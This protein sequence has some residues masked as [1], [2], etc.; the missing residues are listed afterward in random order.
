M[1]FRLRQRVVAAALLPAHSLVRGWPTHALM[2]LM[3]VQ[4]AA[5]VLLLQLWDLLALLLVYYVCVHWGGPWLRDNWLAVAGPVAG[6][7]FVAEVSAAESAMA[8]LEALTQL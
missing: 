6:A 1:Q 2:T 5:A 4:S 3:T 7:L 8:G